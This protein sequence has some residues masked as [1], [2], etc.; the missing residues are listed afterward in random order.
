MPHY[1]VIGNVE[2]SVGLMVVCRLTYLSFISVSV[3]DII[4][5]SALGLMMVY[6]I[7]IFAI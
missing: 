6:I 7:G 1:P 3:I 4:I 2:S 5:G